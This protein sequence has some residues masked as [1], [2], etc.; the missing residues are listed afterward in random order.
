MDL[1][2][3]KVSANKMTANIVLF[4]PQDATEVTVDAVIGHLKEA[5]INYGI[6]ETV[7]AEAIE[8]ERWGD[9][10]CVAKGKFATKGNDGSVKYMFDTSPVGRPK[11]REDG[12]LD[13]FDLH[14]AQCVRSDERLAELIDPTDGDPGIDVYGKESEGLKGKPGRIKNGK[15][16]EFTDE[17]K[18]ILVSKID[19]NVKLTPGG[20]I[21]VS[22]SMSLSGDVDLTTGNIDVV[23]DLVVRGDIKAGLK[24]TATGNIEIGGTVEDAHVSG[25]GSVVVKGGFL[26]EGNGEIK[27][28]LDVFVKYVY[29]Q[30][31][32]AGRDIEIVE[33]STQSFLSAGEVIRILRGKGRL[34]GGVAESGKALEAKIVGNEQNSPTEIIVGGKSD[35][36]KRIEAL[37]K[38]MVSYD[39]KIDK[40]A[41][42]MSKIMQRKK[43]LGVNTQDEEKFRL[44]DKLSADIEASMKATELELSECDKDLEELKRTA[45]ID[46]GS[47]IY[48]GVLIKIAGYVK[49]I[50][51]EREK[52][53]F[54]ITGTEIIGIEDNV[55][56]HAK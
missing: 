48:P 20:M 6:D 44:L 54:K 10:I 50:G 23:G 36:V 30:R 27:A 46:I 33:E 38:N 18:N 53:H 40:V 4:K 37:R 45:Y 9:E 8:S 31:I 49:H 26:G 7:V 16:T 22:Q 25:G 29:R 14:T 15:N 52:T 35:L 56:A 3:L 2:S 19:G 42:Q 24:V 32:S 41:D 17:K 1:F 34:I 39:E 5:S 11:V 51:E 47:N 13:F 28:G 12:T 55:E 21:E 43:K